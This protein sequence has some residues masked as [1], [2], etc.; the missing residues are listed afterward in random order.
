MPEKAGSVEPGS[1]R[2]LEAVH[3][4]RHD[5]SPSAVAAAVVLVALALFSWHAHWRLLGHE[6]WWIWLVVAVPYVCLSATLLLGFTRVI[7]HDRRRDVVIF[8]L[9]LVGIFNVGGV[10]LLVVSL[11]AHSGGEMTGR[12][13]LASGGA[14]LFSDV[15]AFGLAYWEL[16]SGGPVARALSSEPRKPDFQFPQDENRELARPNW[17]P[18]LWDYVYVSL[19]N[20]IAF[21]PTDSMPLTRDA[22][23]LM[24]AESVLSGVTILLVAARAVN[25]L[26]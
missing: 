13:L 18:R 14:V 22:K 20:S 8:L 10:A 1:E 19:T 2:W 6:L 7:R 4:A 24:A 26:R 9:W 11:L 25:I 21:S 15:I 16:D 3:E 17:E 23:R 5:A 12:Q